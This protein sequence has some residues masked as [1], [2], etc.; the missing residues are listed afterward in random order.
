MQ[1]ATATT[2]EDQAKDGIKD[3]KY[4]KRFE[5][6]QDLIRKGKDNLSL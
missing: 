1:E 6:M 3:E 4:Q 2:K 5:S